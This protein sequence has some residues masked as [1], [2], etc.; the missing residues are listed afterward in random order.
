M[1]NKGGDD[2][3]GSGFAIFIPRGIKERDVVRT[4]LGGFM[5][6]P[7]NVHHHLP[8]LHFVLPGK[9]DSRMFWTLLLSASKNISGN[10]KSH[11]MLLC[12]EPYPSLQHFLAEFV[13]NSL[14]RTE[15]QIFCLH[16]FWRISRPDADIKS[17]RPMP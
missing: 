1:P 16:F 15:T 5:P 8:C 6:D 14:R 3:A 11:T 10:K 2:I 12:V 4:Q 9:I 17:R 7:Q 13:R